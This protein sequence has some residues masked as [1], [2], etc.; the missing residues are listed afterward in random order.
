M[1][2]LH[3]QNNSQ[4]QYLINQLFTH[5]NQLAAWFL[6]QVPTIDDFR[7][8][9]D[10]S[11]QQLR[12]YD[13]QVAQVLTAIELG[14]LITKSPRRLYGKAYSSD[15]V[16]HAMINEYAGDNQESVMVICT[17]PHNDII[18]RKKMFIGGS[19]ECRLYLD[20]IFRFALLHNACGLILVH[21]HPSGEVVPSECD[22]QFQ[23]RVQRAGKLI[24]V[25]LLDFLI[26]GANHY[27]S[28]SEGMAAMKS[29]KSV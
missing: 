14:Q 25:R 11:K 8:L 21:N 18:A 28:W 29:L 1:L 7:N 20:R 23:R 26:V 17:D 13:V 5:N 19:I 2:F 16:G 3:D 4:Y 10:L 15:M 24:G 12:A 22:E 9:D 6:Q 27:F